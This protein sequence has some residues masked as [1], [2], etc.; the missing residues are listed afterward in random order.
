MALVEIKIEVVY[1][2]SEMQVFRQALSVPTQS[3]IEE[4]LK[5]S[6]LFSAYPDLNTASLAVGIFGQKKKLSDTVLNDDR[7]EIY[8]PLL[9]DAKQL[10]RLRKAKLP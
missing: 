1:A 8:Q 6:Q 4:I 3:T 10:R 7:I 9:A 5:L 2:Q